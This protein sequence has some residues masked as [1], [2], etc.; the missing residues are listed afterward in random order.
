M[1]EI[2]EDVNNLK[3]TLRSWV[4]R[5]NI[6]KMPILPKVIHRVKAISIKTPM[7]FSQN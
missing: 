7:D 5:I 2:E 6:V 3:D 4:G 1:K